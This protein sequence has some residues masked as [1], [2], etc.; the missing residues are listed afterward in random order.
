MPNGKE[1]AQRA[2]AIDPSLAE[3]HSALACAHLWWDWEA[4][5]AEREFLLALELNPRYVPAR[6]FYA[7]IY[8]QCVA[9]RLEEGLTQAK[10]L[11]E[12]DPLSAYAFTMLAITCATAGQYSEALRHVRCA[13]DLDPESFFVRWILQSCLHWCGDFEESVAAG[14]AGL[15]MSGRHPF[16]LASLALTYA[17]WGKPGDADSLYKELLARSERQYVPALQLAVAAGASGRSEEMIR[18]ARQAYEIREPFILQVRYWPFFE[19]LRKNPRL[20]DILLA[21][22][23]KCNE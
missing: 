22:R 21:I 19:R 8:L 15:A 2:V 18:H 20:N 5:L 3:G 1:A 9:G 12:S 10:K 7:N 6:A 16:G 14:E 13:L 23:L 11:V 4:V 17:D